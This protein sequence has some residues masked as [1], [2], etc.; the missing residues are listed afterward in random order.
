MHIEKLKLNDIFFFIL[1]E[2]KDW[3]VKIHVSKKTFRNY[4]V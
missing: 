2:E 3:L 4:K 1:Y